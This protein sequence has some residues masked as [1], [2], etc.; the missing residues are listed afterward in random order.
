MEWWMKLV[1]EDSP[2][3][4]ALQARFPGWCDI[5]IAVRRT[6]RTLSGLNAQAVCR[7]IQGYGR[8]GNHLRPAWPVELIRENSMKGVGREHHDEI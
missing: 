7:A 6:S 1:T 5:E 2:A 3:Q 4:T 8:Q